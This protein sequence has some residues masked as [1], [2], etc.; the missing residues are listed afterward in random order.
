MSNHLL[1]YIVLGLIFTTVFLSRLF[2]TFNEQLLI[3]A[4]FVV[5][6]IYVG[7]GIYHHYREHDLSTKIVIEYIL[8]ASIAILI[9]IIAIRGGL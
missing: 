7:W 5:S 1:H 4:L 6:I 3:Q 9:A 2:L 8:I